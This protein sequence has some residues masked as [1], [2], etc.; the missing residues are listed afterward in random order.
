MNCPDNLGQQTAAFRHKIICVVA[1]TLLTCWKLGFFESYF[2]SDFS[3][4]F[5]VLATDLAGAVAEVLAEDV[6][7]VRHRREAASGSDVGHGF[8]L[9]GARAR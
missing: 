5:D 3:S 4:R 9:L 6:G 8:G 7:E 2:V 1:T